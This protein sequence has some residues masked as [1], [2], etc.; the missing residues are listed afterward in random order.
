MICEQ[1][2]FMVVKRENAQN[3]VMLLA[4]GSTVLLAL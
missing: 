2:Q 1:L 4:F 3:I